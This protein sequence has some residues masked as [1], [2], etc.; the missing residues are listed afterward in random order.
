MQP[1]WRAAVVGVPRLPGEEAAAARIVLAPGRVSLSPGAAL[2]GNAA[3]ATPPPF[4][5]EKRRFHEPRA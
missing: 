1:L 2:T 5:P 4:R 3:W